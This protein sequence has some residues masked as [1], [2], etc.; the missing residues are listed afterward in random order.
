MID[1]GNINAAKVHD[2]VVPEKI[3]QRSNR[4]ESVAGAGRLGSR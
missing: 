2:L 4:W 3:F 1:N